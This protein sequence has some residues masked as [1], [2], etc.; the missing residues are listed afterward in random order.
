MCCFKNSRQVLFTYKTYYL[1]NFSHLDCQE[2]TAT[3]VFHHISPA[4]HDAICPGIA[5]IAIRGYTAKFVVWSIQTNLLQ[6]AYL[7]TIKYNAGFIQ[8]LY[9][10]ISEAL[11]WKGNSF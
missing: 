4:T 2:I 1:W 8:S 9:P 11:F 6:I 7:I 3:T 5:S 10:K